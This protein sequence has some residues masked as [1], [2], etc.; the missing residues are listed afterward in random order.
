MNINDAYPSRYLKVGDLPDE[1]SQQVTIESISLEEVGRDRD[2]VPVIYFQEF[3]KGFTCNKTNARAIARLIGSIEFDDWI[4]QK[5]TLY[6]T[7]TE[8]PQ[9]ELVDTIR[10]RTKTD[11]PIRSTV[12]PVSKPARVSAPIT[13]RATT[14]EEDDDGIPF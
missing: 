3:K 9:G 8:N 2:T 10:V 6:A 13:T 4:G 11:K 7:E 14:R 1:G 5:I 12:Q